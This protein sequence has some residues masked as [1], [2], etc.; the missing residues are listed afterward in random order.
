M[1]LLAVC[2]AGASAQTA[3]GTIR[4]RIHVSGSTSSPVADAEVTLA[5]GDM[6]TRTDSAGLF[7]F[8]G[9][10]DGSHAIRARRIGFDAATV[11]VTVASERET[12]IDIP[13]NPGAQPLAE[14][15]VS[16]SKVMVPARLA[17]PYKRMAV[18]NGWFFSRASIDS[19]SPYDIKSLLPRI[20][21]VRVNDRGVQFARCTTGAVLGSEANVQVYVDG[22]RLTNYTSSNAGLRLNEALRTVPM[23]SIQLIEVYQG[24]SRIPADYLDDACAVILIWTR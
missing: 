7:R 10:P 3:T 23:A 21:G 24:I 20:P 5:P 15:T 4:G 9:V 17:E 12:V 18:G 16:G 22:T 19:L 6:S 13:I 8:L 11:T 1:A 2:G 14:V